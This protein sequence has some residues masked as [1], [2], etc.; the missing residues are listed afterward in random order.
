[1]VRV[2]TEHAA[3]K[4]TRPVIPIVTPVEDSLTMRLSLLI[5][6]TS[7]RAVHTP[8]FSDDALGA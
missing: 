8:S 6:F 4:V 2:T 1:M 7:V 5:Q 3:I